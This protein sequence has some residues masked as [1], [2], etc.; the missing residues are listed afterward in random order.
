MYFVNFVHVTTVPA[1]SQHCYNVSRFSCNLVQPF[2]NIAAI[3]HIQ[4]I[5]FLL[6]CNI[7]CSTNKIIVILQ[8]CKYVVCARLQKHSKSVK[9][10]SKKDHEPIDTTRKF[11]VD[12]MLTLHQYDEDQ[13]PRNFNVLFQ[14]YF[15]GR[16][17]MQF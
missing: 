6:F 4:Q 11:D 14:C 16:K 15:D 2:Y 8:Y 10:N 9:V 17:V 12:L 5:K 13:I 3:L 7:A 1:G